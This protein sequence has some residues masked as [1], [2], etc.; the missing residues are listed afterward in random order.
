MH[1]VRKSKHCG[2]LMSQ[3]AQSAAGGPSGSS[4]KPCPW[5]A[6]AKRTHLQASLHRVISR[7]SVCLT[8]MSP[9]RWRSIDGEWT[10]AI[11]R[12]RMDIRETPF[13]LLTPER[14]NVVLQQD[15]CSA[16]HAFGFDRCASR[17]QRGSTI[18]AAHPAGCE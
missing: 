5:C 12:A 9:G 4:M 17:S 10:H 11:Q 18:S 6:E 3:S 1:H 7:R 15:L 8:L 16:R 14:T 13:I 2:E